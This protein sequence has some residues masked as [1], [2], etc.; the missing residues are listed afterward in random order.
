M[1][2]IE[3]N[4]PPL[5]GER[6]YPK[7]VV[8]IVELLVAMSIIQVE[9]LPT[10]TAPT[11]SSSRRY[12][13]Q[14]GQLRR[15]IVAPAQ[16]LQEIEQVQVEWKASQKRQDVLIQALK[17]Q[18]KIP[19]RET[20]RRLLVD[21]PEI[22]FDP[23]YVA[24]LRNLHVDV[25]TVLGATGSSGASGGDAGLSGSAAASA[26]RKKK[27]KRPSVTTTPV[28]TSASR[29]NSNTGSAARTEK[30]QGPPPTKTTKISS[31]ATPLAAQTSSNAAPA[32][33]PPITTPSST[34]ETA[35]ASSTTSNKSV[36]TTVSASQSVTQSSPTIAKA[37]E[38]STVD[39][40][41][42]D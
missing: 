42:T 25:G 36:S 38:S 31:S 5:Q 22:A 28:A 2:Q 20:L 40:R 8:D 11:G 23:V 18:D 6:L 29:S 24:A 39:S 33:A 12:C 26:K 17:S 35:P 3:F 14:G 19:P 10:T 32:T 4:L 9:D 41:P 37:L 7:Q 34:K 30:S 13:V 16:I 1:E 15:S 21:S 27:R